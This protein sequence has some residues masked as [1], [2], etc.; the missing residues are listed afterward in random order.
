MATATKTKT[1]T[2]HIVQ[3]IGPVLDVQFEEGQLPNIYDA[4][5]VRNEN[6]NTDG[7]AE[8]QQHTGNNWVRAVSMAS[9][10]GL[11]RGM[12]VED[13]GGPITAPV[14]LGTLGRLFNVTGAPLD[15]K[16]PVKTIARRAPIHRAPPSF[17]AQTA[18]AEIL[19]T[20]MKVIDLICPFL[21]GGKA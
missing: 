9:T 10:D 5:R 15:G 18:S 4:L 16:G 2:G 17:E 12:P 3:I 6:Q 8:V 21:K 1:N 13:L 14:G 20:G 19:E 7:I 11:R